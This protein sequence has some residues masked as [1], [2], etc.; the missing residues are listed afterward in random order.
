MLPVAPVLPETVPTEEDIVNVFPDWVIVI[1]VPAEIPT[2]PVL[3]LNAATKSPEIDALGPVG[4][5]GPG[6]PFRN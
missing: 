5:C 3:P 1:N 2:F 6:I 4:P